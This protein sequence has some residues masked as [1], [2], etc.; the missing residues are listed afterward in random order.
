MMLRRQGEP[1]HFEF[2]HAHGHR[3]GR[4]PTKDNLLVFYMPDPV[5]WEAAVRRM[6][7]AGFE[8]VSAFNDYWDQAGR[9]F[10]DPDGYRVVLQGSA[11]P[12]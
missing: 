5:H 1:Y 11:S 6:Q 4:A 8:P 10:E 7:D 2:T 12:F 9:T 3:V